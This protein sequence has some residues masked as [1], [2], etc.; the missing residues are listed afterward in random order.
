[1]QEA[2]RSIDGLALAAGILER[3]FALA[4]RKLSSVRR[5]LGDNQGAAASG[6]R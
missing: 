1:M 4:E 5:S 3:A 2:M 6:Q